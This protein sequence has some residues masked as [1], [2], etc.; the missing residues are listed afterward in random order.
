MIKDNLY[1]NNDAREKLMTGIRK[2]AAAVGSTMGTG[3]SNA[4]IEAIENPGHMATND[5]ATILSSIRFVDPIE[6]MG[7]KILLEAVSRAN[8]QSGD[9]SSTTTVLTAAIIEAGLPYLSSGSPMDI[10]RSLES[11]IPI[12]EAELK[13]QVKEITVDSVKDV[14]A[15][16]AEDEAIGELIQE[17]YQKI[18]KEGIIH[19]DIS[20]TTK[21]TY[22]IGHG[23]TV[24]GAGFLSPYMCDMDEK[25][26]QFT[27]QARWSNPKVMLVKQKITSAADFDKLFGTLFQHDIKEVV[28]FCD[29]IEAAVIPDLIQTRAIRGFKA[30][31]VKMPVLWKDQWYADLALASGANVVD[32][33]AGLTLKTVTK[34]DLGT[35]GNIIVTKEDTYIDGITDLA[36]HIAQLEKE[37]T[38][39]SKHRAS[40][41]NTKTARLFVGALSESALSYKRLKVEDAV[42]A[43]WQALHGGVVP[44]GGVA[45]I[46]VADAIEATESIG[47]AILTKALQAPAERIAVNVGHD[48]EPGKYVNGVGLD[49]R[50]G[51]YV[52]MMDSNIVNPFHVELN[53]C[54]NAISV[55]ASILTTT[56]V[57]TLPRE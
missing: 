21:D 24:D 27:N 9:G 45:L 39:D 4:L 22:T 14:A 37:N 35:F 56:T 12:I 41:L 31:V 48:F 29:E 16:S 42:A 52:N 49:T 43:A 5:G 3:G 40:R 54:K 30:L 55:A 20:N 33:N 19:W 6:D 34:D 32:P 47:A 8:K 7:R 26:G 46:A 15:I 51:T 36:T 13:K 44:G 38:D 53:A 2:S 23:I 10:K 17:I 57:V 1:V 25:T 11:Y 28:V 50:T 18:G